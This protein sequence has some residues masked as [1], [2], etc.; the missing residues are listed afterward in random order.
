MTMRGR[1]VLGATVLAVSLALAWPAV[2]RATTSDSGAASESWYVIRPACPA[3]AECPDPPTGAS[4]YPAGTLH[5]A[6]DSGNET[7]RTYLA[8]D[9]HSLPSDARLTGGTLRLP[10]ASADAGSL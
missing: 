6:V 7:A 2:A 8:L 3:P 5:V 4:P 10:V 9:L 1:G